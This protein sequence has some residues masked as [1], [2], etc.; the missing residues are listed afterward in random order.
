[1]AFGGLANPNRATMKAALIELAQ[2]LRNDGANFEPVMGFVLDSRDRVAMVLNLTSLDDPIEL[3]GQAMDAAA[4][5]YQ[6]Q[7]GRSFDDWW[8]A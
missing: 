2:D 7:L 5:P 6:E 3:F 4:I 8:N 1:M